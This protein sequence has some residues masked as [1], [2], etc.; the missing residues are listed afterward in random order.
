LT[1]AALTPHQVY[2]ASYAEEAL[3]LV[4]N[5]ATVSELAVHF[6]VPIFSV[7]LW[8][9]AHRDFAAALRVGRV[10]ADDRVE[11]SLYNRAVGY[12]FDS[13]KIIYDGGEDGAGVVRVPIQEHVPPDVTACSLWLRNRRPEQWHDKRTIDFNANVRHTRIDVA[14]LSDAQLDELQRQY[15]ETLDLVA[16]VQPAGEA[17]GS[18]T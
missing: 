2:N 4:R 18:G 16:E 14:A 13:E 15:S 9:V 10:E 5:G 8:A 11:R 3:E 1:D 12:T 7:Q 17:E 6:E